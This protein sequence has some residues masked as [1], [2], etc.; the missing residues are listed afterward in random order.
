MY[1]YLKINLIRIIFQ[2]YITN[3]H[4]D[5]IISLSASF[6]VYTLSEN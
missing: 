2:N 1:V 4:K 3:E 5:K 6:N